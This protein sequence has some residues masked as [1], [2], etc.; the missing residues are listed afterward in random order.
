VLKGYL[1][2]DSLDHSTWTPVFMAVV[3]DNH[4]DESKQ[5]LESLLQH[6]PASKIIYFDA[7]LKDEQAAEVIQ[8]K[9]VEYRRFNFSAYSAHVYHLKT[10]AFKG[11]F[12]I[13]LKT[14]LPIIE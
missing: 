3:S 8:F 4:Y 5:M 2:F 12:A 1:P 13:F 14:I 9:N 7:G 6:Y 10:Y 11:F